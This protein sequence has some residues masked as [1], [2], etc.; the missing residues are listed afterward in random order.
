VITLKPLQ[1]Q[2]GARTVH[3]LYCWADDDSSPVLDFIV[4]LQQADFTK[5]IGLLDRVATNGLPNNPEK[6]KKLNRYSNLHE[7]KS[8]HVRLLFFIEGRMIIF[9][10]AFMKTK[11]ST[12]DRYTDR[13]ERRR[14]AYIEGNRQTEG[15][16][17]K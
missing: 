7:L 10:E 16:P 11:W 9:T 2:S 6:Y 3:D 15:R 17:Y 12:D 14:I 5:L 13:A 8:D 4:G 1:P